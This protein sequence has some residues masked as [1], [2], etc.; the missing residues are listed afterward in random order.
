MSIIVI[1]DRT[2]LQAA[3]CILHSLLSCLNAVLS[4]AQ[5]MTLTMIVWD[6]MLDCCELKVCSARDKP[7]AVTLWQQQRGGLPLTGKSS[8]LD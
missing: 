8:Q 1:F 7:E 5:N 2:P 3:L 6:I 4:N